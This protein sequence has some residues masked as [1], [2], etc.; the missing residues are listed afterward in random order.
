MHQKLFRR[1]ISVHIADLLLRHRHMRAQRRQQVYLR[2]AR[3]QLMIQNIGNQPGIGVVTRIIRG[4]NQH[5]F[6]LSVR[7][8]LQ[9]RLADLFCR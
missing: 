9:Q 3:S 5:L 2:P 4:D 8:C 6:H 7:Q 1:N